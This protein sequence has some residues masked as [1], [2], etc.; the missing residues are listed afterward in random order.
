MSK[1]TQ[2]Q[3]YHPTCEK[4]AVKIEALIEALED[5]LSILEAKGGKSQAYNMLLGV[6]PKAR[7]AIAR[8][9]EK[10]EKGK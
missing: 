8:A 6:A 1:H 10:E 7:K 3:V 4:M 9:C 2:G 5:C